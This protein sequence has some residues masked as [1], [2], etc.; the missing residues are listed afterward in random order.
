MPRVSVLVNNH[1]YGRFLGHALQSVLDQR[2]PMDDV[3][4]IAVDDGSTDCSREVLARF[5]PR[6]RT[7]LLSENRGQAAAFNAGFSAASG[8]IL[9][10]L[11]SDDWWEETKLARVVERFDAEKDLGVVQH[12]CREVSLDGRKVSA[13]YPPVPPRFE[14]QDFLRGRCV[15][16]GTTG[17]SFR[18]SP[19]RRILPVPEDLRI[20]ADSYLYFTAL[21]A[22]VG[23]IPEVLAWRRVHADNRY[24]GRL[25]DPARLLEYRGAL[26][27][28]DREL[29]RMLGAKGVAL[30]D[31]ARG[32]RRAEE[33][34]T[35][36]FLARYAG[37]WKEA[38]RCWSGLVGQY[39]GPRKPAKAAT[40][41]LALASPELY[42]D[43]QGIYARLR[44]G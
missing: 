6:V 5:A 3:E 43:L 21:E 25:R 19:L 23:N 16:T 39:R 35:D 17:L 31:E 4:I 29:A 33:L 30:A 36:L 1:N 40:L 9:C 11:D 22:P 18:A 10:L 38:R 42:L 7:V 14:T 26:T 20:S 32:L 28:L 37:D 27:A 8:D 12:W 13:R 15:F 41:L 2:F 44:N 34:F 24:A